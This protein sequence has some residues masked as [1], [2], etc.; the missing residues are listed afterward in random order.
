MSRL[1]ISSSVRISFSDA[2]WLEEIGN[3]ADGD[4]SHKENHHHLRVGHVVK[5]LIHLSAPTNSAGRL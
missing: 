3:D 1:G 5:E 2:L 4:D